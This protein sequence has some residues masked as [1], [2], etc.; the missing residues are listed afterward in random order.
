MTKKKLEQG[1]GLITEQI[2]K[3]LF[4]YVIQQ[5]TYNFNQGFCDRN[6]TLFS[7]KCCIAVAIEW[8]VAKEIQRTCGGLNGLKVK[9]ATL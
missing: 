4:C 6:S 7:Y 9:G 3:S 2:D 5:I 8:H 1:Q